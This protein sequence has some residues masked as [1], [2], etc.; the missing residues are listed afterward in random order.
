MKNFSEYYTFCEPNTTFNKIW[1]N[2][3]PETIRLCLEDDEEG[4]CDFNGE[5]TTFTL[6]LV[7][8]GTFAGP[9]IFSNKCFLSK[10][11]ISTA[12]VDVIILIE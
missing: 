2:F 12:L 9:V 6:N 10:N 4:E 1:I 5:T 7:H 3:Y 8:K 11:L